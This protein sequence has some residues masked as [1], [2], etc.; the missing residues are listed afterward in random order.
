M[1]LSI[2]LPY[3]KKKKYIKQTLN[4]IIAQSFKRQELIII[5]DQVDTSDIPYIKK[6][7][8]NRIRYKIYKNNRNLGVGKS[9]NIGIKNSKG[10]FIAFCDA[11]DLW[12]KKK[13]EIQLKIMQEKNLNFSHTDYDLINTGNKIIG[14]MKVKKILGYKDLL[15]SCDV[16]LSS[17]IIRRSILNKSLKFGYTK[18]KEDYS[19]WLR[20]SKI[21]EIYGINKKLLYWRKTKNSLS[22]NILQKFYDAFNVYKQTE[23]KNFLISFFYVFR[24]STYYVIK[25]IRQKTFS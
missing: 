24:L 20:I 4:S 9:R 19:L 6:I 17:V 13:S 5:Y 10:K 8:K 15:K 25:K 14:R 2:I 22:S 18:T 1:Y 11:D 3:F 12:H 7:L 23:N 21:S 16:A